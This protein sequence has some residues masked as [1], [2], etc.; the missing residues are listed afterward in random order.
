MLDAVA[1]CRLEIRVGGHQ[2]SRVVSTYADVAPG[3]VCALVGS[4]GQLEIAINGAN[5]AEALALGRGGPVHV[6]RHA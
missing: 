2:L 4:R 6:S 5:A 1:G 3:E